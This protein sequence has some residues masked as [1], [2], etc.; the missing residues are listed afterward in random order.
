M[1]G[2]STFSSNIAANLAISLTQELARLAAPQRAGTSLSA[3]YV[4][5][6][7]NW[8]VV[9]SWRRQSLC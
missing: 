9:G 2:F 7:I 1:Y 8:L 5:T 3:S 6:P 4:P